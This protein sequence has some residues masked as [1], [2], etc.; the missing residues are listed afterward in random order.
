MLAQGLHNAWTRKKAYYIAVLWSCVKF[1]ELVAMH[2][3]WANVLHQRQRHETPSQAAKKLTVLGAKDWCPKTFPK[4]TSSPS[5]STPF[6]AYCVENCGLTLPAPGPRSLPR[7]L[8][9]SYWICA[10]QAPRP[11]DSE[12][13]QNMT[14]SRPDRVG[15]R[16]AICQFRSQEPLC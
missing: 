4:W 12:V 1:Q 6:E 2:A 14:R 16:T 15:F 9:G 10:V 13:K 11:F 7:L 5:R 8:H 3:M